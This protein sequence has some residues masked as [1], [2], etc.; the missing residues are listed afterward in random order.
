[1]FVKKL[2]DVDKMEATEDGARGAGLRWMLGPKD[3]MP[4]F[5]LRVVELEP[6][7]QS[8]HHKHDYEHEVYVLEGSG[9]L[10]GEAQSLPL[11][12]GYAGYVPPNEIHQFRNTG[13]TMMKFICVIPKVDG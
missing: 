5:F 9:E 13:D 6:G 10:A 12:P 1:M 8:M 4:N 3:D 2:N 7:G 11:E